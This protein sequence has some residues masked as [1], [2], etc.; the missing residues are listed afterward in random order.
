MWFSLG[1]RLFLSI[2]SLFC[3]L[4]A[5]DAVPGSSSFVHECT[6]IWRQYLNSFS[7]LVWIILVPAGQK[8]LAW[9]S[10]GCEYLGLAW[11]Y[12]SALSF[13]TIFCVSQPK[14]CNHFSIVL[15]WERGDG[16]SSFQSLVSYHL[17]FRYSCKSIP[18]LRLCASS[19]SAFQPLRL[20][21]WVTFT[22]YRIPFL[23]IF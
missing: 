6:Q 2:K 5:K 14:I 11:D 16:D 12:P 15:S 18:F 17:V 20:F 3:N 21:L 22:N 8:S 9:C 13:L 1:S 7:C 19:S 23:V 4:K 10:W